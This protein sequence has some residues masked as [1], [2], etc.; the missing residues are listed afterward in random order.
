MSDPEFLAYMFLVVITGFSVGVAWG[1]YRG[2]RIAQKDFLYLK[3]LVTGRLRVGDQVLTALDKGE[4]VTVIT[5][6]GQ[7]ITNLWIKDPQKLKAE[8]WEAIDAT[9]SQLK[10]RAINKTNKKMSGKS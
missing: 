7:N 5:G 2:Y 1:E 9:T 4:K 6:S 8:D 10:A 3:E